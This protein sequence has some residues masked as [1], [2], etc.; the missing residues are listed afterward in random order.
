[1]I[2]LTLLFLI[3]DLY[4]A[5]SIKLKNDKYF[6]VIAKQHCVKRVRIRSYSGQHFSAFSHIRTED[7]E[8]RIQSECRKMREKC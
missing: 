4:E 5:Y 3:I 6:K 8:I 1:M 7:G 2:L